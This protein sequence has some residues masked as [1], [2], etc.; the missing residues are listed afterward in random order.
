MWYLLV[1][2][3]PLHDYVDKVG[4]GSKEEGRFGFRFH[5]WHVAHNSLEFEFQLLFNENEVFYLPVSSV[6]TV[7]T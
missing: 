5:G 3:Y 1:W 6:S 7:V 4:K 2:W